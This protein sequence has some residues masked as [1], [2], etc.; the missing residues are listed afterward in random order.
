MECCTVHQTSSIGRQHQVV[1][2]SASS[3]T[4]QKAVG[5]TRC[6]RECTC[7]RRKIA[8]FYPLQDCFCKNAPKAFLARLHRP[9]CRNDLGEFF[10]ECTRHMLEQT[11]TKSETCQQS[12]AR[13]ANALRGTSCRFG[14]TPLRKPLRS[15]GI[16]TVCPPVG[17]RERCTRLLRPGLTR[18]NTS[19]KHP[20][21]SCT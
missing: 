10:A 3:G 8:P 9:L 6:T 11:I 15:G 20:N 12:G 7:V 17:C 5:T 2:S 13:T 18:P 21:R 1:H 19:G 4:L 16:S 14:C